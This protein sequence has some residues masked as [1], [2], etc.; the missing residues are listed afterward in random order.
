MGYRIREKGAQIKDKLQ[1]FAMDRTAR[2]MT[3]SLRL[4]HE[5]KIKIL[6]LR[7]SEQ[8]IS[9]ASFGCFARQYSFSPV[10]SVNTSL[11]AKFGNLR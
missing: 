3:L 7:V 1:K 4:H 5:K 2:T 6:Y 11:V 8:V 10:M 9:S